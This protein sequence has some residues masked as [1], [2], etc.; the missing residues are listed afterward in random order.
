[1]AMTTL[2]SYDVSGDTAR[3]QVAAT[4]QQVG[5][6]IQ[7]SVFVCVTEPGE[8]PEVEA[9][10]REIIDPDT[11]AVH[12]VPLCAACWDKVIVLGQAEVQPACLYWAVL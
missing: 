2:I 12:I 6:R 8:L 9:R 4:L 10:L 3:A 11:D 1:M 5:D 7:R